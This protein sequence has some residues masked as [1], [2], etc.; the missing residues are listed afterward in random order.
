MLLL[1]L[2]G[3]VVQ[4]FAIQFICYHYYW[5]QWYADDYFFTTAS[6]VVLIVPVVITTLLFSFFIVIG[7]IWYCYHYYYHCYR[8]DYD[9]SC[10]SELPGG[11][12]RDHQQADA[13]REESRGPFWGLFFCRSGPEGCLAEGSFK[14]FL[15]RELW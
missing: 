4:F 5:Y 9:S 1:P 15:K 11:P 6:V 7:I 2:F 14:G 3:F 13:G 12:S 8:V 10:L